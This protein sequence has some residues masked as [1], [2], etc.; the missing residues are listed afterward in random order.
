MATQ[1]AARRQFARLSFTDGEVVV[2]P[3]DKDIFLISAER[4][5][6]ACKSAHQEANRIKRFET[7]FLVPLHE[8]CVAHSEQ[9][10]SCYIP[11]AVRPH[12][13]VFI[14]ASSRHFDLDF[15]EKVGRLELE[16]SKGWRVGI[17]HLPDADEAALGTFFNSEGAL[18]VYAKQGSASEESRV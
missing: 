10:R 3:K 5:T 8:W 4:A 16:L 18:E 17:S 9:V 14:V 7:E 1:S 11:V 6:E 13:Q 12:V 15:A 2:K